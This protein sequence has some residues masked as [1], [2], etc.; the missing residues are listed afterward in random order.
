MD[1]FRVEV[2]CYLGTVMLVRKIMEPTVPVFVPLRA[3]LYWQE[4]NE[5]L[6]GAFGSQE[7]K[8]S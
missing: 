1:A 2:A 8:G 7:I 5:K 3:Y 6:L 4:S